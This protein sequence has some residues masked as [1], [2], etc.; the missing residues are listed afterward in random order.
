M[1]CLVLAGLASVW[2]CFLS[3]SV[4]PPDPDLTDE[5]TLVLT[6]GAEGSEYP[7]AE[8]HVEPGTGGSWMLRMRRAA[9]GWPPLYDRTFEAALDRSDVVALRRRIESS[10]FF[11]LPTLSMN[12]DLPDAV[13]I[14]LRIT[15]PGGSLHQVHVRGNRL[16]GLVRAL[17]AVDAILPVDPGPL[18]A[19]VL[20]IDGSRGRRK[21]QR[22]GLVSDAA[23]ALDFHRRWLAEKPGRKTLKLDI[24]ALLIALE[25]AEEVASQLDALSQDPELAGFVPELRRLVAQRLR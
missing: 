6:F 14:R 5:F 12:G 7:P 19:W 10:G 17:E 3:Q 8:I 11:R 23:R 21:K 20:P 9:E 22:P 13:A 1:S 16:P 25:R 4:L 15:L 24:V 18:P 2:G